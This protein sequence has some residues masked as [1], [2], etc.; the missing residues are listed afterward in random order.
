M[1]VDIVKKYVVE[2]SELAEQDFEKI[3]SYLRYDLS[4]DIIADKYKI[5]FKQR[6]KDLENL[7]DSMPVL[8]ERLTGHKSIRKINVRNY[9]IFYIIDEA[10]NKALVLRIGHAFMDWEKYLKDE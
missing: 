1:G 9:I 7:A 8:D 10:K 5:L 2:I 4:G 3:I 6:L